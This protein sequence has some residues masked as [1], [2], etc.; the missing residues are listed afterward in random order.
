MTRASSPAA[1]REI[2]AA[3]DLV[4]GKLGARPVAV[5]R[6]LGH[7]LLDDD[8]GDANTSSA[9]PIIAIAAL[10]IAAAGGGYALWRRRQAT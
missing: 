8:D 7:L 5:V 2:A 3:A 9:A 4:K 6:G 10:V 1:C